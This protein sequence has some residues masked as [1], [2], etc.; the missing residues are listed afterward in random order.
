[1]R[2]MFKYISIIVLLLG[3]F[4]FAQEDL[5]LKQAIEKGL[6][7]NFQVK[8]VAL[9]V[10]AA[11]TQNTW[12]MAGMVPTFSLGLTNAANINDNTNNPASFFPGLTFSDNLQASVDMNWTIFSG[13]GI[14]INKERFDQLEAQ[15]KGNAILAI[16]NTIYEIIIA[17]YTAVNQERK[18]EVLGELL[19]Y[20]RSKQAYYQTKSDIGISTSI[21]QIEFENQVLVDSSNYLLQDLNLRNSLRNLNMLMGESVELNYTLTDSLQIEIPQT[22]YSEMNDKMLANNSSLQNQYINLKLKM[23]DEDARKSAYYPVVTLGLGASPSVGYFRLFDDAMPFE[24]NTNSLNY[25]ATINARYT[26]FN[27]MQRKRNSEI[28]AIQTNIATLQKDELENQLT[29]QLRGIFELYQTQIK[30]EKM[31]LERLNQTERLWDLARDRYNLGSITIFNLN[32]VKL[33]YQSAKLAYYDRIFDLIKTHYD[34]MRITGEISQEYTVA[35]IVN[36]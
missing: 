18:L 28:A 35:G 5:S 21:D 29:H 6:A 36:D 12:G 25:F 34:L 16:E 10:E 9:N 17:Y 7:N 4:S 33:S 14:R 1:M 27:G 11:E 26:L 15:T 30:L 31:G 24:A 22:G 32:D 23:L 13:F 2:E 19:A 8:I 3:G 20:S